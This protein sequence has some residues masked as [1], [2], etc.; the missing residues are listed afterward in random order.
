MKPFSSL[1]K[2][3]AKNQTFFVSFRE[4]ALTSLAA[5]VAIFILVTVVHYASFSAK[6]SLLVLASMG[7]STFLLFVV[8]HSPMSQP[9]PVVGGH[10]VSSIM[11]V[12]CAKYIGDPALATAIAVSLSIF[13]MYWLQCLHPPSA[14]TAMIAVLGGTETHMMGWQFCYEVV[15]INAGTMVVLSIIINDFILNRR[16]PVNHSHHP[17]HEKFAKSG[18]TPY[19]EL[20]EDDFKY[21]LTQVNGVVDIGVE[22]LV[23]LYEFAVEHALQQK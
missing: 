16:Y 17:H 18:H 9:W 14:A 3:L 1:H 12:A 15:V 21:A 13:A 22:D 19:P 10:L 20:S 8:P 5:F 11:G 23:D 7:A 2:L 4:I 6:L